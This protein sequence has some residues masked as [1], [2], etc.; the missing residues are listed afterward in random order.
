MTNNSKWKHI[1]RVFS[2]AL[3]LDGEEQARF[4]EEESCGD[5]EVIREVFSLLKAHESQGVLDRNMDEVRVSAVSE[6]RSEYMKGVVIGKYRIMYELGYGGMGCVFLAERVDGEFEQKVALKLLRNA[7]ANDHQVQRFRSERQILASLDHEHIARL[8]D[9]GVTDDGRPWFAMERIKGIPVIEFCDAGSLTVQNRLKLFLDICEAVGYAHRKLVIHRDLKPS[10]I[11]VTMEGKVKL[12]DFGIAKI[13]TDGKSEPALTQPGLLPYTPSYASPEQIRGESISTASDVYQLGLM[14]YELIAGVSPY[15][16]SGKSPAAVEEII[17]NRVPPYPATQLVK[18]RRER[19]PEDVSRKR[20]V[21]FKK[22]KKELSGE[23]GTIVMKAIRKEP[24]RRYE[25]AG[26]LADD[27]QRYLSGKPVKAHADS[28]LYRMEKFLKRH[29]AGSLS[30]AA[31]VFMA[32]IYLVTLTWHQQQTRAAL[33]QAEREAEKSAQVVEFMLGMFEAGEPRE[34]PGDL[35]T[36]RELLERGL[37]E[38]DMLNTQ[39]E[40]QANMYNVIGKVYSGLGQ[41]DDAAEILEKAVELERLS[42]GINHFEIDALAGYLIDLANAK[43]R[44]GHFGEAQSSY[45]EA[46]GMLRERYGENH[47]RVADAKLA[48]GSWIPVAGLERAAELRLNALEIRKKWFG[49]DDLATAEAFIQAGQIMRSQAQPE[50]AIEMLEQ[51]LN[52]Q[53]NILGE[54]HPEVQTT[55]FLLAD[56]YRLFRVDLVKAEELYR[57]GLEILEETMGQNHPSRLHG[58]TSLAALLVSE[59]SHSEAASLYRENLEIRT[60][61][62]G[63]LHPSV[64]EGM[65][66][67]GSGFRK[68]GLYNE[69]ETYHRNGLEMWKQLLDENHTIISGAKT[70]LAETLIYLRRFDEAE[71][72]LSRSLEIQRMHFGDDSGAR[73]YSL[74]GK[75]EMQRGQP[76]EAIRYYNRS[77]SMFESTGSEDHYDLIEIRNE[78]AQLKMT[79]GTD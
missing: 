12:L 1:K 7:I 28:R 66:Q 68:M 24:E 45:L 39:P 26:Q 9:G 50:A 47:P 55:S 78:L 53:K 21:S 79:A 40:V 10:N 60:E 62:F 14:L 41:F 67:A 48:M 74:F 6:A 5:L 4:I 8:L 51:A 73:I 31:I 25:S 58:I 23:L 17:C 38:A 11:L 52:I 44:Q 29:P 54:S 30:A 49:E 77:I 3:G 18:N 46:L 15:D 57:N 76:D 56:I 70:G 13:M 75:L 71:S 43:V 34:N 59:G 61:I 37:E 2:G 33:S 36:A 22:L 64:A 32:F 35:I 63:D 65:G 20:S 27:I 69:S 19:D 42:A 72:L 16:V